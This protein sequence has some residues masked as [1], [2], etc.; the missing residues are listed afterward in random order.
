MSTELHLL[1]EPSS[2]A[3]TFEEGLVD[4]A[5]FELSDAGKRLKNDPRVAEV[6]PILATEAI[7]RVGE[8]VSGVVVK[9]VETAK[10]SRIRSMVT[11]AS[12]PQLLVERDGA[13]TIRLPGIF[14]GQEL[15]YDLGIIPGDVVLLISPT[16]TEGPLESVPRMKRYVLE[17]VYRSGVP[18]QELHQVFTEM[19]HVRAFL[20]K[21]D[22]VSAWEISLKQFDQAPNLGTEISKLAPTYRVKDW[23]QMNSH[24]FASLKLERFAMFIVLGFIVVV[25]SFNIVTTLTLMVMEK[26]RDLSIL[27]AMGATKGALG[28]IFLAEGLLIGSVGI[29]GGLGLGG[30]ICGVLKRYPILELPDV[31]YDRTVPVNFEWIYFAGTAGLAGLIV[32]LACLYPS[33]RAREFSPMEGIRYGSK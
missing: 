21:R 7:L 22:R 12:S 31:Y 2:N 6:H 14:V 9:G 32:L 1:I 8:K 11:E 29:L 4:P 10:L 18:E 16:Q 17:G 5:D 28:A 33:L 26:K 27:A 25:A 24:L 20:R 30:V 23:V 19:A 13:E 3:A 15:A